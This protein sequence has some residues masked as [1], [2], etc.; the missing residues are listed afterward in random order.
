MTASGSLRAKQLHVGTFNI[1]HGRGLDGRVD[2]DRSA[3]VIRSLDADVIALQ[4]VD[5][6]L[7]RSG[8]EDQAAVLARL[9]GY[10]IGFWPTIENPGSAYGIALAA[11][12]PLHSEYL[13][14]PRL[15]RE[16][17]RGVVVAASEG[18]MFLA[19]HLSPLLPARRIQ[20][21][22]LA[23]RVRATDGPVVVMGDL[24]ATRRELGPLFAAGLGRPGWRPLTSPARFP[25]RQID[26]LLAG[27]G[28]RVLERHTIRS[29]ASDH[30][31][32]VALVHSG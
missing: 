12:V 19:T 25:V 18:V 32:V 30:L 9:T 22:T 8:H 29:R 11:R 27:G 17:P 6:F 28:A 4:E 23:D 26:H 5:R 31:P 15:E 20:I 7:E 16:E 10:E 21:Q 24:N 2:L 14:L 1:R 13:P 3:A